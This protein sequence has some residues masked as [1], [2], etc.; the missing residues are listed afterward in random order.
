MKRWITADWH[1][2][3]DRFQIMQRPFATAQ[4]HVDA[5]TFAKFSLQSALDEPPPQFDA[6]SPTGQVIAAATDT[7]GWTLDQTIDIAG[8]Q[9]GQWTIR[10]GLRP[11]QH[12]YLA[13]SWDSPLKLIAGTTLATYAAHAPVTITAKLLGPGVVVAH[14]DVFAEVPDPVGGGVQHIPMQTTGSPTNENWSATWHPPVTA[15]PTG[16]ELACEGIFTVSLT[17]TGNRG[18]V[19]LPTPDF[20]RS[21]ELQVHVEADPADAAACDPAGTPGSSGTPGTPIVL[22]GVPIVGGLLLGGFG[23]GFLLGR[24]GRHRL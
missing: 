20:S 1:L 16:Q 5:Q 19:A 18:T 9:P 7:N 3:E 21:V 14:A 13:L 12:Y 24:R 8:P 23:G 17:A 6:V 11:G 15:G 2:G 10:V 4:M 22:V